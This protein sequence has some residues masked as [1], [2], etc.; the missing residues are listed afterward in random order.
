VSSFDVCGRVLSV[1]EV[2]QT[3]LYRKV[4]K[5]ITFIVGLELQ[6]SVFMWEQ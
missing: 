2:T 6:F 4:S 5:V 1:A 3:S